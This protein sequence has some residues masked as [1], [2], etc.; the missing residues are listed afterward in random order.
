MISGSD[1]LGMTDCRTQD[2]GTPSD[3][4]KCKVVY[5][6]FGTVLLQDEVCYTKTNPVR[7]D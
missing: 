4:S 6:Y 5:Q 7:F 2:G 1:R 3:E